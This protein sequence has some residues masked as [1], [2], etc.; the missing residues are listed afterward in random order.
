MVAACVALGA[1]R[2]P[3][4]RRRRHSS[5]RSR[6][7]RADARR[8]RVDRL[9]GRAGSRRPSRPADRRDWSCAGAAGTAPSTRLD[10]A[11]FAEAE[12]ERRLAAAEE[13]LRTAE[14][15]VVRGGD[16]RLVE[17]VAEVDGLAERLAE[18]EAVLQRPSAGPLRRLRLRP[19]RRNRRSGRRHRC[20][21]VGRARPRGSTRCSSRP[22]PS[23][24]SASEQ[25]DGGAASPARSGRRVERR[26]RVDR[27]R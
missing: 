8:R 10:A 25:T 22:G 20:G 17:V 7:G 23:C 26:D 24:W 19:A 21:P 3:A 27:R 9:G 6:P 1:R 11:L 5:R 18:V 13:R 15:R 4:C 12:N 2:R 16:T 14:P